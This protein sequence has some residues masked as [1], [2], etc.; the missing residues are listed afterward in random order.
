[1]SGALAAALAAA[2]A[3]ATV[4]V[5]VVVVVVVDPAGAAV[6]VVFSSLLQPA[7]N[8]S[9]AS[10]LRPASWTK[11]RFESRVMR[12]PVGMGKD[13]SARGEAGIISRGRRAFRSKPAC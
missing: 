9:T 5:L 3:E 7:N 4:V 11:D 12:A 6:V 8:P 10:E 2:G 13:G 1:L